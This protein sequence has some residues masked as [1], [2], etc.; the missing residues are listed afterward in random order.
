M[1]KKMI[2]NPDKEWVR[3]IRRRIKDNGGYCPCQVERTKDTKCPC[4]SFREDAV[5]DC[6]LFVPQGGVEYDVEV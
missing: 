3:E 6:Q 2:L 1:N 5:C 4:K